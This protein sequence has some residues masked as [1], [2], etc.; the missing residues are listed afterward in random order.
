MTILFAGR[1]LRRAVR[2]FVALLPATVLI[3]PARA[4]T[5]EQLDWLSQMADRPASGLQ[6]ASDQAARGE[7]LDALA[8]LERVLT[9]HPEAKEA[10]LR[11]AGLLC[12]VDDREG[13][14]AEFSR[15]KEREFEKKAWHEAKASCAANGGGGRQGPQ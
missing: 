12:R 8:T 13:A 4:E 10:Q 6:L 7:L 1:G 2:L 14:A 5:V 9:T 3:A 11:H 15:L